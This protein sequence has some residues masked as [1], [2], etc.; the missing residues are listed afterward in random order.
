LNHRI[1]EGV[2]GRALQSGVA[3]CGRH[4]GRRKGPKTPLAGVKGPL[5]PE[6]ETQPSQRST[7]GLAQPL[8]PPAP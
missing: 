3:K 4:D 5:R 8:R 6:R 1:A 7:G 2:L